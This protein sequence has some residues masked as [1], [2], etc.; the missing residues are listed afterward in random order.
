MKL[1]T[2]VLQTLTQ[3]QKLSIRQQQDLKVLEMNNQ[4][5]QKKIEEELEINPMLEYDESYETGIITKWED[6]FSLVLNYVINEKTLTDILQEQ[7]DYYP[8]AIIKDVAEF[9]IQSLDDNGYLTISNKEIQQTFP[10]YSLDDIEDTIQIIQTFEPLGVCARNLQE[11]ILIQLCTQN[12]SLS[13]LA[14]LLVNDYLQEIA[15]NKLPDIANALS[16]PLEEIVKA[17]E[18]IRSTNPRPA[19]IYAKTSSYIIPDIQISVEQEEIHI[20]LLRKTFGL[21]ISSYPIQDNDQQ[22]TQYIRQ[23]KKQAEQLLSSIHKRNTTLENIMQIICSVQKDFFLYDT[24][25][26]PFTLKMAAEELNVHESTISRAISE[27]YIV[28]EGQ[29]YSLKTFFPNKLQEETST[30]VVQSHLKKLIAEEDKKKP[31]SDQKLCDLLKEEGYTISRR[32]V[33]KYRDMLHIPSASKR[34]QY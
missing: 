19:E 32:T 4:D 23:Q 6:P 26:K 18:L 1:E 15:E 12:T 22:T 9:I 14:I 16:L 31:H 10:C 25:L 30:L 24:P 3:Q 5:L 28:F 33:A 21:H 29:I 17:V 8:H 20:Y 27:K 11:C 13:K 2:S 34:K 7:I